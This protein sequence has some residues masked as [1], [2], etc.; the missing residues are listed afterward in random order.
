MK[1]LAIL[2]IILLILI[3]PAAAEGTRED[4][5]LRIGIAKLL[6]HPA[7][8]SIE[9]GIEDY[10]MDAGIE[11]EIEVQN[12]NGE[13]STA[14]SIAQVF[15]TE[16]K[17]LVIGIATPTA[18]AL[19]NVFDDIPVI[20]SSVTDVKAAGLDG[21]SNVC[22][23]SDQVPA[24]E[25]YALIER[26]TG[27]ERIIG[28]IYTSG[29]ANGISA[30]EQ[31]KRICEENGTELVTASV[32]NS[33]EV[34]MAALSII[35]RIDAMYVAIDNTV[36]SAVASLSDVCSDASIP[37]FSADVT[38]AEGTDVLLAGGFDYY[39]SGRLTGEIVQRV[40]N[41]EEPEE[42]G[43]EYLTDLEL[44]INTAVAA[45]LG[46]EIPEEIIADA[47]YLIE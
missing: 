47:K 4:G 35:D 41:G 45:E 31:M 36:V 17:D 6:S 10:L 16:G 14:A 5:T 37:L 13:I 42:I 3:L 9:Q 21:I 23:V 8:D 28:M 19:A 44:Y 18:Q 34:R 43:T 29:E 30:M 38:S 33:S 1:K 20:Y 39:A 40:L 7:L 24:E 32:A 12:A 2:L 46:L 27:A 11:A 22:G 15:K 26:I 25:H